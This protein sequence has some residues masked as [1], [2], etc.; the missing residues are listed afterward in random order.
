MATA[1]PG[2]QISWTLLAAIGRVESNHGRFGGAAAR[3]RRRLPS[4]DPRPAARRRRCL[5]RDRGQRQRRPGPR[6]GL[7]PGRGPDAVPAQTW[8]SVARDGDG[9]GKMNPDDIDDSALGSAVYLCGAGGSLADPA[10]M[11]RA[12]FRYNHS[13]YYVQLV[14]S[15]QAGY[16]TGVFAVPSPPPPPAEKV[17]KAD[18]EHA[19]DGHH[20]APDDARRTPPRARS[21]RRLPS[22]RRSRAKPT[23]K[24]APTPK[25]SPSPSPSGP[26]LSQSAGPGPPATAAYCLGGTSSTSARRTA[27]A[28]RPTPTSTATARWRPTARSSPGWSAS[29]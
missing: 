15:F 10:G 28:T 29:T 23:P 3:L 5:R 9:D 6:Q 14:L 27:G 1:D 18:E 19:Q 7:G 20:E 24:P 17:K 21:P 11:A 22:P 8:Q 25:P 26:R 16:Q 13:D 2:C 12:A 4:G